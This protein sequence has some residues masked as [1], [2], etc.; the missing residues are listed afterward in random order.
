MGT[1]TFGER[2]RIERERLGL[3]QDQFGKLGGMSRLA[4]FKYEH[5]QHSPSV[6]YLEKLFDA[7]VDAVFLLTG[8][9]LTPGQVDWD[10]MR[11]AFVFVVRNFV[12]KEGKTYSLD[13]LFILFRDL[14]KK[15]MSDVYGVPSVGDATDSEPVVLEKKES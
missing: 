9:R 13:D 3:T 11:E 5:D 7:K 12:S 1:T 6:E 10:V 2:L 14:S 8:R 4:Q 15:M